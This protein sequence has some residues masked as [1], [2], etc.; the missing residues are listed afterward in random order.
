MVDGVK[1]LSDDERVFS[2]KISIAFVAAIIGL[3]IG[4][5]LGMATSINNAEAESVKKGHGIWKA[6]PDGQ[7]I[8][9][10]APACV[11]HKLDNVER[12]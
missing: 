1:D 2:S 4:L 10:W 3:A 9:E 7:P 5:F 6:A 12:K 8:F 11:N